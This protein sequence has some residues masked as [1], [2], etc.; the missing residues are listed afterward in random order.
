MSTPIVTAQ[1]LEQHASRRSSP[2]GAAFE[3]QASVCCVVRK[4]APSDT[5]ALQALF[6][7]RHRSEEGTSD[8]R[9]PDLD[10][11]GRT[12][13]L[14]CDESRAIGMTSVQE[15]YLR[16]R[17]Q[18][19]RTAYWTGLFIDPNYR[20]SFI[21]PRLI[22]AMFSGIHEMGICALYAGVRRQQIA[23]AHLKI[24][25]KKI[26]DMPVLAKL[27]RPVS[28]FSKHKRLIGGTDGQRWLRG[29]CSIPDSIVGLGVRLQ[30]PHPRGPWR[31]KE[32][33][34]TESVTEDLS[35]LHAVASVGTNAQMWTRET[36]ANRYGAPGNDYRVIGVW[37]YDRCVGAAIVRI[38]DRME[39]IRACVIM[40]LVY[41]PEY[42]RAGSIAL[43]AVERL[44]LGQ[45]CDVVLS[46]DGMSQN[47]TWLMR[48]RGYI[49]TSEKYALLLWMNRAIDPKLFP[50]DRQ[51][52]RFTFGDHDTF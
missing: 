48:R 28:L 51:P 20:T 52:W 32:V 39:G 21:Y 44:A 23:D 47:E 24:G 25:F 34:W 41:E 22:S 35:C 6:A 3:R 19:I 26:A 4:A 1:V 43:A 9:G 27:L 10:K 36:L 40:N 33:S 16:V 5:P 37:N 30:G 17:G 11:P 8:G 31:V 29:V 42:P 46:L 45:N 50:H 49:A 2:A 7:V 14:A 13:W 12:L 15:R 38:V 18:T